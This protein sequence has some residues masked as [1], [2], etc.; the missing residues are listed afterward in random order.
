MDP[1]LELEIGPGEQ[2]GTYAV[3]VLRSVGAGEPRGTFTL[4]TVALLGQRSRLEES[5]LASAVAASSSVEDSA[6]SERTLLS[7]LRMMA[8]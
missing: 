5:V 6:F 3:R 1:V 8:R 7:G 4:D 2:P